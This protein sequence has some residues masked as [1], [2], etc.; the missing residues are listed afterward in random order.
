[1]H[2]SRFALAAPFLALLLL[3][4]GDPAGEPD[5]DALDDEGPPDPFA[6]VSPDLVV[7][8]TSNVQGEVAPC[9]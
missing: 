8:S 6:H 5:P 7:I 9:G 3:G 2:R 4:A 1:L